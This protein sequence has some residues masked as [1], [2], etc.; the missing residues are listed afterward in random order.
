MWRTFKHFYVYCQFIFGPDHPKHG[1]ASHSW[2]TG[3]AVWT[4]RAFVDWILG[5][6]PTCKGLLIDPCLPT[7]WDGYKAERVFRG[8]KY[9]IKVKKPKGIS[10]GISKVILDKEE[11]ESD[12]LPVLKDGKTHQVEVYMG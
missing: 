9:E 7:S 5:I 12:T 2:L 11:L 6:R 8:V 1:R 10:K 3:T 4:F